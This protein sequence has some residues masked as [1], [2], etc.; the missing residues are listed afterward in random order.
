MDTSPHC[1]YIHIHYAA[2]VWI[3]Y[4]VQHLQTCLCFGP[5]QSNCSGTASAATNI[6]TESSL[7][8]YILQPSEKICH[9]QNMLKA[10]IKRQQGNL[11]LCKSKY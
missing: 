1:R 4:S 7:C 3:R 6:K 10:W 8:L 5:F 9:K 11:R 2:L